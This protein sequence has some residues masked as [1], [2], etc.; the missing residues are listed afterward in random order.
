MISWKYKNKEINSIDDMPENTHGFIYIIKNKITGEYYI[1]KKVLIFNQKKKLGKKEAALLPVARGR[2]ATTK[3]V[4]KESDWQT[5]WGSS[6]LLKEQRKKYKD[7]EY[8]KTILQF[9]NDKR[10]LTYLETKYQFQY[11]VLEDPLS[12]NDNCLGRFFN[13]ESKLQQIQR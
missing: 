3:L 10:E 6:K 8:T 13:Q 4:S 1:G 5:Y 11:N 7:E 2:K 12:L 9:T